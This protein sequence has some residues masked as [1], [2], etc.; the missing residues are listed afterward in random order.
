MPTATSTAERP[1]LLFK[2]FVRRGLAERAA[3]LLHEI[4]LD[5]DV[6]IAVEHA[7]DVADLLLGPM[8][9]HELVRMQDVTADLAAER[10]FLLRAA[11]LIELRLVLFHLD[12]IEPRLEHAH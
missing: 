6:D 11:N 4:R 10:D 8:I 9:L 1:V 2:V 3:R 7:V 12:V 5:E